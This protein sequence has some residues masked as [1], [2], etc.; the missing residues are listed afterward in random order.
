M[1]ET[2][3]DEDSVF[4]EP[5]EE[6]Q[7]ENQEEKTAEE[8]SENQE[9]EDKSKNRRSEIAQKK[10]WREKAKKS[11]SKLKALETE[12][13]DLKKAVKKPDD[14]KEA[15]AQEY[16][17]KQARDVFEQLEAERK[18]QKDEE[19]SEFEEKVEAILE[20]NPDVSEEELLDA[21]EEYEVT[22]AVALKI[23]Q[24][25]TKEKDKKPKMPK[26]KKASPESTEK[27][28]D[29]SKKN[30]WDILKEEKNRL[31]NK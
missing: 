22:P 20:D 13:A 29:D 8:E 6:S 9:G 18:K 17:R 7:E 12:L 28:P 23:L 15:A 25:G 16:I 4:D 11:D 1:D 24:K 14:E 5:K 26:S 10:H 3:K 31:L 19:L 27:A 30:M 21:I 2:I